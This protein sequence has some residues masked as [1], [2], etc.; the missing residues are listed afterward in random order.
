MA[1]VFQQLDDLRL[2]RNELLRERQETEAVLKRFE[3]RESRQD[4]LQTLSSLLKSHILSRTVEAPPRATR[5]DLVESQ[6]SED[7][8]FA[9][10]QWGG[11]PRKDVS[12]ATE[13][14]VA[15]DL[16]KVALKVEGAE[17]LLLRMREDYRLV[18]KAMAQVRF[19]LL[20][21]ASVPIADLITPPDVCTESLAMQHG[22]QERP[23]LN[24]ANFDHV[25]GASRQPSVFSFPFVTLT[26]S[27]A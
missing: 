7:V 18:L 17:G 20:V 24:E 25:A 26:E 23:R 19:R 6:E 2:R 22:R 13:A 3:E 5:Y 14:D 21:H 11:G 15:W 10:F 8:S 1:I 27:F 9:G 12:R 16:R 4:S